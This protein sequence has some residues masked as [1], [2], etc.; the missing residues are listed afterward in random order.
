MGSNAPMV[1]MDAKHDS[2]LIPGGWLLRATGLD[3]LPQIINVLR[4][5][6]TLVGPRPCIPYEYEKYTTWQKERFASLPGLTGLWQVSGKNKTTFNEMISFDIKYAKT[7]SL[8]LDLKIMLLTLPALLQQ[9]YE[10][11]T[12]RK[13]VVPAVA[14]P[15]HAVEQAGVHPHRSTRPRLSLV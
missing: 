13:T 6:M 3:E 12:S 8:W 1:K 2:R 10:T 14:I 11:R 15:Q 4:G 7:K 9:V 5:D